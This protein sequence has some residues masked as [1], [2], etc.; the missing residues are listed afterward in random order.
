MVG[1]LQGTTLEEFRGVARRERII[2][3]EDKGPKS[4]WAALW[5]SGQLAWAM[6]LEVGDGR[7]AA[8]RLFHTRPRCPQCVSPARRL[9]AHLVPHAAPEGFLCDG[10]AEEAPMEAGKRGVHEG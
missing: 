5:Q 2:E 7:R 1:V 4:L 10:E 6:A 3:L 9:G 8:F